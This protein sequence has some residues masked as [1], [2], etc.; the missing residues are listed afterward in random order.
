MP[1][2]LIDAHRPVTLGALPQTVPLK[3]IRAEAA[4]ARLLWSRTR[5]LLRGG[6]LPM[7][8]MLTALP[9]LA[10]CTQAKNEVH[11][12]LQVERALQNPMGEPAR[13]SEEE[14]TSYMET[15]VALMK[16]RLVLNSALRDP[17]VANLPAIKDQEDP[18]NW[19]ENQLKVAA[20]PR[21]GIVRV[22][23]KG[24]RPEDQAL[25]I[26]AVVQAYLTETVQKEARTKEVRMKFLK[27]YYAE[28]DSSLT[29]K[30]ETLRRIQK[31]LGTTGTKLTELDQQFAVAQVRAIEKD[32]LDVLAQIRKARGEIVMAETMEQSNRAKPLADSDRNDLKQ[33]QQAAQQRIDQLVKVQALLTE[34]R[35]SQIIAMRRGN[36]DVVELGWLREEVR[37]LENTSKE[38]RQQIQRLEVEMQAPPRVSLLEEAE[39]PGK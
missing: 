32:L 12:L 10:G 3:S 11:A 36:M 19:L 20:V 30:R 25:L 9:S 27:S 17:K 24:G 26:N 7:L 14:F 16:T 5:S 1:R 13:M 15:Q 35:T 28:F 31:D 21:T 4:M 8:A 38:V 2:L 33:K 18:L 34:E 39:A 37:M 29:D 23:F 6:V 22:A